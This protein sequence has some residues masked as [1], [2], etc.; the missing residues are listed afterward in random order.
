MMMMI[1]QGSFAKKIRCGYQHIK[2]FLTDVSAS[3]MIGNRL[4]FEDK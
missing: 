3:T 1:I 4:E 2:K